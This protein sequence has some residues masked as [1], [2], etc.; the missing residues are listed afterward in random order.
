MRERGTGK[1]SENFGV[2][3]SVIDS[4]LAP[5]T[6]SNCLNIYSQSFKNNEKII[7]VQL[8]I[9]VFGK[10]DKQ[11]EKHKCKNF[12]VKQQRK[13]CKIVAS[14][15]LQN[16]GKG[17]EVTKIVRQYVFLISIASIFPFV[18]LD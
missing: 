5:P 4:F 7:I 8:F 11:R 13:T 17:T 6:T 2:E 14:K 18:Y 16:D 9:F 10:Q 12:A 1:T 15:S 3:Q